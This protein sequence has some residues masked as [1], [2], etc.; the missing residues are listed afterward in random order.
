MS[1]HDA[2]MDAIL[3]LLEGAGLVEQYTDDEGKE[4]MRLTPDGARVARQMAMS[5]DPEAAL[6][7]LLD[8]TEADT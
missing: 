5:D 7:S 4:A 2:E 3:E 8:A 6:N 1:D